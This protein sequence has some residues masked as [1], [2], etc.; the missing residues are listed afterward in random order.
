MTTHQSFV[1]ASARRVAQLA[2]G[3]FVVGLLLALAALSLLR[4]LSQAVAGPEGG[5]DF[6]WSGTRALMEQRNPFAEYLEYAQGKRGKPYPL[7]QSPGYPASGY[8]FL[9]PFGALDWPVARVGW[10]VANVL[11]T[12]GIVVGLQKWSPLPDP[13][14]PWVAAALLVMAAG[15]R[16]VLTTGQHAIFVVAFFVWSLVLAERAKWLAGLLLAVS[17]FKYTITFP[18]TFIFL[19]RRTY[20][21]ILVAVLVHALLTVLLAWWIHVSPEQLV[22]QPLRVAMLSTGNS[23]L[24][25]FGLAQRIGVDKSLTSVISLGLLAACGLV[26]R[27]GEGRDDLLTL[28]LLSLVACAIFFHLTYDYV[29]LVFPLWYCLKHGIR[30]RPPQLLAALVVLMWYAGS[31]LTIAGRQDG[32]PIPAEGLAVART[33]LLWLTTVMLYG[34]IGYLIVRL[35]KRSEVLA[36]RGG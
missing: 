26:G 19:T 9:M 4:G 15:Y 31:V 13:R 7:T 21:V 28:A 30:H 20:P 32:S 16:G 12:I 14:L 35:G 27:L 11:F 25:I 3:W 5:Q 6:Q 33:A 2:R 24:D 10:A 36:G 8:V 17:W 1:R 18:L 34:T 29:V 23:A 22:L